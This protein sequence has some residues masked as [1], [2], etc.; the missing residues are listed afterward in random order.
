VTFCRFDRIE[1]NCA[2]FPDRKRG[3]SPVPPPLFGSIALELVL[4]LWGRRLAM[5]IEPQERQ[6]IFK[7]VHRSLTSDQHLLLCTISWQ[8]NSMGTNLWEVYQFTF[9]PNLE[10]DLDLELNRNTIF[11]NVRHILNKATGQEVK[12]D[13]VSKSWDTLVVSWNLI[14]VSFDADK[15]C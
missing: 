11:R 5:L 6:S 7:D 2:Q 15:T 1:F 14:Q 13:G 4:K 10:F 3:Q 8:F 9:H 12:V